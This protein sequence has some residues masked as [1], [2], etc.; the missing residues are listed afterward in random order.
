MRFLTAGESHGP[1]VVAIVDSVPAGLPLAAEDVNHAL[2]ILSWSRADLLALVIGLSDTQL[3]ARKEGQPRSIRAILAQL[4]AVEWWY[5]D[6]LGLAEGSMVETIADS[7]GLHPPGWN[8]LG[9]LSQQRRR[10]ETVL[11]GLTGLE[12]VVGKQAEFWSP[13]KLVRR[14]VWHE[15]DSIRNILELLR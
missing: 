10:L 13:R 4:G 5:L 7:A 9:Y 15:I 12:K 1:A 2:Q 6:R 3:D 11:P 8:P 14:A